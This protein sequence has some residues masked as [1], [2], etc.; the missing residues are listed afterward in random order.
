MLRGRSLMVLLIARERRLAPTW[1]LAST[2]LVS[3][4]VPPLERLS[5][6]RLVG[7]T[8]ALTLLSL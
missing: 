5:P 2:R 4:D 1:T 6:D 3:A 8:S 7:L